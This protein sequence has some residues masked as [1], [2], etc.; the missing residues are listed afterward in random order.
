MQYCTKFCAVLIALILVYI[1][2]KIRGF[3][4]IIPCSVTVRNLGAGI[5]AQVFGDKNDSVSEWTI[6]ERI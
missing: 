6:A 4:K 5:V 1:T 2:I 3:L